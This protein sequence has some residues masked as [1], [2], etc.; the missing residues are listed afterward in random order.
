MMIGTAALAA[1]VCAAAVSLSAGPDPAPRHGEPAPVATSAAASAPNAARRAPTAAPAPDPDTAPV[2]LVA[3]RG[4]Q[5]AV[6]DDDTLE[7]ALNSAAPGDVI[8]LAPGRYR[9]ISITRSGTAAA[10]ITLAGPAGAVLEGSDSGY[11]VHLDGASHWQLTGFTV[12]GGEKG[13]VVDQGQRNVL[14]RLTVGRTAEEG[15]HFRS[16]SSDNVVQHSR[17]H[18]TGLEKPEFGEGVYI[19]SA[20]SNWSRYVAGG[21]PDLSMRN[22]VLDTTF[23]N[24]AAENVDVKEETAGTVLARNL[25]DGSGVQGRNS[26]DSVVDVKGYAATVVDNVTH[27]SSAALHNVIE[28]HVITD[29]A[30]SGCGNT[31]RNN[32]V[33]GFVPTGALVAVDRKCG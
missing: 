27:G 23:A 28:T 14:D 18:D 5:V 33:R 24:T 13:V 21:G 32:T 19:G 31:F 25:F 4:R 8:R 15:I 29:P 20:K 12:T 26:A 1:A 11:A 3:G 10:P 7:T 17:V 22:R 6:R 16:A 30:T 2:T 9:P